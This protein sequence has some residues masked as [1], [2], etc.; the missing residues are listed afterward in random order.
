MPRTFSEEAARATARI[1]ATEAARLESDLVT[2]MALQNYWM[3]DRLHV[4]VGIGQAPAVA[5]VWNDVQLELE[6]TFRRR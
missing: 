1:M 2:A 3:L 6:P 4:V 5:S